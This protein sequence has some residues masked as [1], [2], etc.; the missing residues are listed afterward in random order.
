MTPKQKALRLAEVA[1]E[2]R[3][4]DVRVLD[5]REVTSFT[6]FFVIATATSARHAKTVADAM[7]DAA[8]S[9]GERGIFTEG[10][11]TARWILVDTGDVVGHVF[12]EQARDFY[13]LERLWGEADPIELPQA[14]GSAS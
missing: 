6:D 9:L 14:A 7:A 2:K 11:Q 4:I 8:R 5:L 13:S 10:E 1:T 12:Q 3:G